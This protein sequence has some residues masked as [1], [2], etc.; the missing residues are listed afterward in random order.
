MEKFGANNKF[1]AVDKNDWFRLSK[2]EGEL[3]LSVYNLLMDKTCANKYELDG[4]RRG[5]ILRLKRHLLPQIIEQLPVLKDLKRTLEELS[6]MNLNESSTSSMNNNKNE[7]LMFAVEIVPEFREALLDKDFEK[8]A[9]VQLKSIFNAKEYG[10]KNRKKDMEILCRIYNNFDGL[11]DMLDPPVCAKCGHDAQQRCSRC[12]SEWY[13][14][15]ECQ[16]KSWKKHKPICNTIA[17]NRLKNEKE[18]K[19]SVY[20]K[21]VMSRDLKF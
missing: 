12:K 1:V 10:S 8:I 7:R 13:C 3:W 16:L 17:E 15:R 4:Y 14:S 2:I 21:E 19:S 6:I 11:E 5:Q 18:E 9:E 20:I